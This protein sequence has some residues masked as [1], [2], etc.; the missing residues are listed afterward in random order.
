[1]TST[2]EPPASGVGRTLAQLAEIDIDRLTKPSDK[3]RAAM[4]SIGIDNVLDLLWTYPRRYIDRTRQA[5]LADLAIGDEAVVLGVVERVSS[6][7]TRQGRAMVELEVSDATGSMHVVFFNQAWRAKQLAVGTEALFFSKL[8]DYRGTRQMTNPIVDVLVGME[9]RI[10]GTQKTG[11]II[12]VYPQSAR[13]GLT[14]FEIGTYVAEA[15]RRSGE[16]ADPL[17]E[18]T[19]DELDLVD[20]TMAMRS[21]HEPETLE[22]VDPAR[23]RLAFDELLRLQLAVSVRKRA[24]AADAV[25]IA[26]QVEPGEA[27]SDQTMLPSLLSG[28]FGSLPYA[29]TDAQRRVLGEIFAD[30]AAPAPMHRLLQG[31]VGS[32]KT[33]VALATMLAA[34]QGGHQAALMAPTEVLAEQH[35]ASMRDLL[36]GVIVPDEATLEGERPLEVRLLTSSVPAKERRVVLEGLRTGA[37]DLVVGTHALLGEEVSFA[38]LGVAV[39]D[40]QHRFGVEQRAQL[41]AKGRAGSAGA[42]PDLLVMTATPIPRTAAMVL[43]GDLEVSVL[44]EMPA[45]RTPIVT[46]WARSEFEALEA[47]GKVR[48]EVAE[49]RQA[50]VVCPLIEGSAKTVATSAVEEAERLAAAEL[51]GLRIGLLHGQMKPAE[52]DEVMERFRRR[53]LDVLVAT[54]VIE[55]GVDVP[56]ATVMVIEDADRFGIAQLHQ[57]RG[58]VGRGGAQGYCYLLGAGESVEGSAR[59]EA[60]EASTDGFHLAEV[61]LDLRGEGTIL[62]SRQKG[63]SDLRL[64]RLAKDRDLLEMAQEVAE[65]IAE[66]DPTLEAHAELRAELTATL[67]EAE[68]E[69][70]FKG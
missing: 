45:G 57:L 70:L 19:L 36:A 15:L 26:H 13:S 39:V 2:P 6:R 40:E 41:R 7:R 62:G 56:N 23:R 14:S 47:F 35:L 18:A 30:L 16:L 21:I 8:E 1:M 52:K 54:T 43:F 22:E 20:R 3:K 32:G 64:A 46:R 67:D 33:L 12:S 10:Q 68:A 34:V 53:E 44:D 69:Y 24:M 50:Y 65:R 66:G 59:L 17:D 48:A 5:D 58:R 28:F 38:S 11:K 60:L 42:D 37:V 9:G 27:R 4:R 31:D 29:P 25:G 63:R 51:E 55:V 61:D 49:G